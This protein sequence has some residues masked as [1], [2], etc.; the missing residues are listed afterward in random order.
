MAVVSVWTEL[1]RPA[2]ARSPRLRAARRAVLHT[3]AR[4]RPSRSLWK[5]PAPAAVRMIYNVMLKREPDPVGFADHLA[6]VA[7]GET[8]GELVDRIRGSEEFQVAVRMGTRAFGSSIHLGRCQFIRSLPRATRIIDLGGTHLY[9]DNGALVGLGYPYPFDEL[10]II[11]LPPDERH[12]LYFKHEGERDVRSPLGPVKYRYHSMTDLSAYDDGA[13]DLVYSGQSIEHV[14]EEEGDLV[15]KQV[16]RVLRPGGFV[17]IDTPN[18]R[19][20]RLQQDEFVDPDHKVEY[21]HEEMLAKLER[22]GFAVTDA[23]GLNYLGRSLER[24]VWDPTEVAGN[25]GLHAEI[26]DCY[27]LC[28]V[29]RKD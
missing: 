10:V 27:I 23:K 2:L 8:Y 20:T 14:T 15:L 5:L 19:A 12:P 6:D 9:S 1:V 13:Y 29:A 16:H 3:W 4:A 11:D 22:A 24:G 21:T 26:R 18:G 28:Y 17:A 7:A 25:T